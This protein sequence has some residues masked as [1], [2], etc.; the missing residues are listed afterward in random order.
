MDG[1]KEKS[2]YQKAWFAWLMLVVF[3]PIGIFLLWRYSH[4]SIWV[5]GAVSFFFVIALMTSM[6]SNGNRSDDNSD[7]PVTAKMA[8]DISK[9]EKS[10]NLKNTDNKKNTKPVEAPKRETYNWNTKDI[11]A[12]QNGNIPIAVR[13]MKADGDIKNMATATSLEDVAKRPWDFY[14]KVIECTGE[15]G[16][17]QDYP[18]GSDFSKIMGGQSCAEVVMETNDGTIVD[19]FI[20]GSSGSLRVGQLA[21]VYG[22]PVGISEVPNKVGGKFTHLIIV[23]KL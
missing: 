9:E 15:V 20:S 22:Y 5:R 7:R 3:F 17:V 13:K 2:F 21:T 14:G 8:T 6:M 11:D 4:H 10:P 18:P 12:I 16:V 19:A 23:G 1:A